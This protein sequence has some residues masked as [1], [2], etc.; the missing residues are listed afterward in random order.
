MENIKKDPARFVEFLAVAGAAIYMTWANASKV[1]ALQDAH[2]KLDTR[3]TVVESKLEDIRQDL[4]A[5][6]WAVT[7]GERENGRG[8]R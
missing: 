3:V 4:K 8:G 6:R 1:P 2:G 7:K 5:I